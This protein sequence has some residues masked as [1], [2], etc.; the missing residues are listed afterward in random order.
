MSEGSTPK[1][2]DSRAAR[3]ALLADLE[4]LR[5]ALEGE[6]DGDANVPILEDVVSEAEPQVAPSP[7]ASP[8]D[9][10]TPPV[11]SKDWRVDADRLMD[12][13]RRRIAHLRMEAAR[14]TSR[15]PEAQQ[16][17]RLMSELAVWLRERIDAELAE[18]RLRLTSEMET[19][20]ARAVE[21]LFNGRERS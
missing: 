16:R 5:D 14:G 3:R 9:P 7:E 11:P 10:E 21:T 6:L 1:S 8:L 2:R 17:A 15:E 19:Q 12:E 18:M 4:S 20:L 13:A